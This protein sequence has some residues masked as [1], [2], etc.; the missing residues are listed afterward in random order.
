MIRQLSRCISRWLNAHSCVCWKLVFQPTLAAAAFLVALGLLFPNSSLAGGIPCADD[1][2]AMCYGD[3]MGDTV[4]YL[5][6]REKSTSGDAV[7][8]FG[9]PGISGNTLDFDPLGFS[10]FAS[11]AAGIDVTDSNLQFMVVAK[12]DIAIDNILFEEAGDVTLGG[13]FPP[14]AFASVTANVF[15]DIDQVNG[16]GVNPVKLQLN[17]EF[18]PSDGDFML[19]TDGGG[20]PYNAIWTG[21]LFVD[22]KQAI[23][24]A[25][26]SASDNITK[27]TVNLDNTL[28]AV[29][30][31]GT[32][33]LIA[34]K[35][36]D[37]LIVTTNV[38]EPTACMLAMLGLVAG[39]LV[40]RRR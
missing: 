13:L 10:A 33:A 25:G 22:L 23:L 37:G 16:V 28:T 14:N 38:P 34:K 8:L 7:P 4:S 26:Y 27:I 15:I 24:D 20:V 35:D 39:T 3:F 21:K 1:P 2:D 36:A 12:E 31:A 30:M 11:G 9:M 17:M 32:S 6:V 40:R 5:M 19:S 18:T 29:S